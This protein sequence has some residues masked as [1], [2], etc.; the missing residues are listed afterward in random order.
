MSRSLP[1]VP[2]N[3]EVLLLG[4][5]STGN[6]TMESIMYRQQCIDA[7]WKNIDSRIC[8]TVGFIRGLSITQK[9]SYDELLRLTEKD[10]YTIDEWEELAKVNLLNFEPVHS[11]FYLDGNR[12]VFDK[13]S[14]LNLRPSDMYS[15][16]FEM[17]KLFCNTN[18]TKYSLFPI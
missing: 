17:V 3:W 14:L 7:I 5:I 4:A 9:T 10:E 6:N 16:M 12:I 11:V 18:R 13:E 15:W 1:W 2:E 8:S